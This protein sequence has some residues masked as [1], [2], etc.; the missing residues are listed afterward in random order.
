MTLATTPTTQSTNASGTVNKLWRKIQGDL[1]VGAQFESEEYNLADDFIPPEGTPYSAREVTIP[2]DLSEDYGAAAIPEFGYEALE[3]SVALNEI[4]ITMQMYNARFNASKLAK[5]ADKGNTN[6]VERQLRHQGAKKIQAL[7]AKWSDDF[8]GTSAGYVCQTSTNATATSGQAY[9][10]INLYGVSGLGTAAQLGRKFQVGERV[11]L[12]RSAALVSNAI[13]TITARSLT[14]PSIT[15][16]WNGSVDADANDYIVKAN[17]KGNTDINDTD[18]NNCM[19]GIIDALTT[20]SIHGLSSATNA[21]YDV[22]Y[23]DVVAGR[24]NGVKLRH[25]ADEIQDLGNGTVN[26]VLMD[27]GVYRDSVA[28]ERAGLRFNDPF[29]MELDGDIKSK[30]RRFFRT[31][32]VPSGM[33]IPMDKS[34]VSKWTLIP[35]PDNGIAWGDGK[36]YIDQ[37]GMVFSIDFPTAL[38]WKN[39]RKLSYFTNQTTQ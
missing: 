10:L 32:R 25:A 1:A 33:V 29:S 20:A 11:A 18:Y 26:L 19:V 5:Y 22:A 4:T 31:R 23:S 39:R 21:N 16:T 13:G 6:Q 34:A 30:G 38:V 9:T 27:R 14:T 7:A 36:E 8:Y 35:K 15:V 17:S 12:I 24:F 37:S 3:S 28:L 2:L